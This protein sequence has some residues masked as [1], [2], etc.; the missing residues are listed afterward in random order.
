MSA[1]VR[2]VGILSMPWRIPPVAYGG[3]E[4]TVDGLC[5]GLAAA[6]IEVFLWSHPDSTCPVTRS[7]ADIRVRPADGWQSSPTEI[8]HVLEGY[9]WLRGQ[10]V[11]I[12]HDF[13][14]AGPLVGPTLVDVPVITTNL[15]PFFAP[16]PSQT[17]PD[18]SRLY[19]V[20][21]HRL[22]VLAV[23]EGQARHAKAPLAGVIH[24]GTELEAVRPGLGGGDEHG[25][26]VVFLGRM[27][28]EKGVV[29]AIAAAS[30]AGV[31][32]KV[33]AR[34][35]EASEIEYY[36]RH[37]EPLIDGGAIEYIGEPTFPEKTELLRGA[38]LLV[39]PI[40]W[41]EPFGLVMIEAMAVGTPVVARRRGSVEEI[42]VADVTGAVCD[43]QDQVLNAIR[44]RS[45]FSRSDCRRLVED[46][47]SYEVMTAN[48]L[49][50]YEKVVAT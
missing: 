7:A 17:F 15:L 35:E 5:R 28:P 50:M 47:F 25:E 33:A 10:P 18:V 14:L 31:R 22:P 19:E 44:S 16:S 36:R 24:L 46:R 20:L 29:D 45:A 3:L 30:E 34:I 2:C 12:V 37:V 48:H 40:T 41:E 27:A 32:I 8:R 13:T 6:G 26:Y 38:S 23:S 39:N 21:G 1:R 49:A 42:V 4:I 11:D 43:G 9:R